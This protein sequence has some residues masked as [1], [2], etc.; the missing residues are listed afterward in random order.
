MLSSALEEPFQGAFYPFHYTGLKELE[1]P[2]I[3]IIHN[4]K[5]LDPKPSES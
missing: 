2:V 1:T 3:V 5:F 4:I